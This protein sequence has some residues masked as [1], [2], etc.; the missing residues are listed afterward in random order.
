MV[1]FRG[2]CFI[3]AVVFLMTSVCNAEPVTI[4]IQGSDADS[5]RVEALIRNALEAEPELADRIRMLRDESETTTARAAEPEESLE[6][7]VSDTLMVEMAPSLRLKERNFAPLMADPRW[8]R[9]YA[10]YQHWM[11]EEDVDIA[12]VSF[13]GWFTT[14][15]Y[16]ARDANGVD[17]SYQFGVQAGVFS[18]FDLDSESGNLVNTDFLIAL[19]TFTYRQDRFSLFTRLYHQSSHLGDEYILY[20]DITLDERIN[21]SYEAVDAIVSWDFDVFGERNARV[22]GGPGY[23]LHS[24]PKSFNEWYAHYGLELASPKAFPE[25][26]H[27]WGMRFRPVA[28]VDVQHWDETDWDIKLSARGGVAIEEIFGRPARNNYQLL[29]EY[30][31]GQSPHGQFLYDDIEYIGIGIHGYLF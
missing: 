16:G 23:I 26:G 20:N 29:L 10:A 25:N 12:S 1:M 15:L 18:F 31:Y 4:T 7:A 30:Y 17:G 9:F 3:C 11:E 24:D 5:A 6:K 27:F 14:P 13:G 28:A 21:L 22:Y 2:A 8:P 19:P